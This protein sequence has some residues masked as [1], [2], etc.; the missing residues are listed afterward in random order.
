MLCDGFAGTATALRLRSPA[1]HH[2]SA[3]DYHGIVARLDD[4]HRVIV[5]KDHLQWVLQ[6]RDGE[7]HGRARWASVGYFLTRNALI[8]SSRALCG[9]IDPAALAALPEH[10][11]R[12]GG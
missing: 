3:D 8:R 4:R 9:R 7:R 2:E 10:F 12:A 1:R 6:R 11:G 5:C